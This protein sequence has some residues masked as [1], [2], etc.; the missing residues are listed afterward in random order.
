MSGG[1]DSSSLWEQRWKTPLTYNYQHVWSM[2]SIMMFPLEVCFLDFNGK[3]RGDK[4]L[5]DWECARLSLQ[6]YFH[7]NQFSTCLGL[8]AFP[9][10]IRLSTKKLRL[11]KVF[12]LSLSV[13][14][15]YSLSVYVCVCVCE[16][17]WI[18]NCWG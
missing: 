8:K 15:F 11:I 5:Q 1:T 4:Y 13:S 12:S 18:K 9:S 10:W 2:C 3:I 17:C 16:E 14:L 7:A 6:R